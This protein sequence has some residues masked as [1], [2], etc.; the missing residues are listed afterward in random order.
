MMLP[1][2]IS[3]RND[4]QTS[5]SMAANLPPASIPA[6][7]DMLYKG[8]PVICTIRDADPSRIVGMWAL[9]GR[10]FLLSAGTVTV[11]W[12]YKNRWD[13]IGSICF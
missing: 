11:I 9:Q 12:T 6:F 10:A 3:L 8:I 7:Y 1:G 2:E 4:Y 5:G 13:H